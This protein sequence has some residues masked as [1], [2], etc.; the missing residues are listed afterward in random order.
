[1]GLLAGCR[2]PLPVTTARDGCR[3]AAEVQGAARSFP[4]GRSAGSGGAFVAF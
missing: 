3:F 2:C 4:A 1:M